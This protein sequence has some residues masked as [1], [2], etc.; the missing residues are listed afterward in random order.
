MKTDTGDGV[1][2]SSPEPVEQAYATLA[3][4]IDQFEVIAE[5]ER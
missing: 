4:L 5:A 1:D 3:V 2:M